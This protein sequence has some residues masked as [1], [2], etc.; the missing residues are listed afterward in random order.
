MPVLPTIPTFT[1]GP[2]S[3]SQMTQL[4]DALNFVYQKPRARLVQRT[5]QTLTT[6]T[7]T[8][9]N[10]DAHNLDTDPDGQPGHSDSVNNS[11][12]TARY[13]G[14]YLIS[15]GVCFDVSATGG[16]YVLL[17]VNGIDQEDTLGFSPGIA[18][19]AAAAQV[20]TTPIYLAQGDYVEL[21]GWQSSGANLN[22]YVGSD[23]A[24][25]SLHILWTSV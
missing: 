6:S 12:W 10:F 23:Y 22:T 2:S 14:N 11:R 19:I 21:V 17:R 4:R 8:P 5:L 25:S 1:D 7:F 3:S 9:I 20:R 18:A 13:P 24:R 15:G 16:R